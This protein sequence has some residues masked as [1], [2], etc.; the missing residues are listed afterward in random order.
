[1]DTSFFTT[2]DMATIK[3]KKKKRMEG[4]R[5]GITNQPDDYGPY[6]ALTGRSIGLDYTTQHNA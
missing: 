5:P 6:A 1:M 4:R 2:L 3:K